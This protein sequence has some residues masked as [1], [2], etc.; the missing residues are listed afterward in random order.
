M[1]K[2]KSKLTLLPKLPKAPPKEGEAPAPAPEKACCS[3]CDICDRAGEL[4]TKM[5]FMKGLSHTFKLHHPVQRCSP[6][7]TLTNLFEYNPCFLGLS[8]TFDHTLPKMSENAEVMVG[9]KPTSAFF[10]Y[11][12]QYGHF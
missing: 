12:K 7:A 9:L 10:A 1:V 3:L 11:L 5:S 2:F 4:E 8:Y 6:K